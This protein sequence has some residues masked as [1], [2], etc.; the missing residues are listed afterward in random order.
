[1]DRTSSYRLSGVL[2]ASEIAL[3]ATP[4][5]AQDPPFITFRIAPASGGDAF[6]VDTWHHRDNGVSVGKGRDGFVLRIPDCADFRIARDGAAVV[7]APEGGCPAETLAQLLLDQVLPLVLHVHGRFSFHASSVAVGEQHL[8]AFLGQTGAG[9]STLASS[10]ARAAPFV[11]FSDDCLAVEVRGE[12]VVAHPSYDSTRLW[13][14]SAGALFPDPGALA[15]A[16]P[17]TAKLRA[18]LAAAPR[19]MP[20]ERLYLLER[21]EGAP[22][23]TS[24]TRRDALI[25]LAGHLY[26]LDIGDR[27]RLTGELDLLDRVTSLVPVARLAYRRSYD[28]LPAVRDAILADLGAGEAASPP[29]A[30]PPPVRSRG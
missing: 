14:E 29:P 10:L 28:E 19:S 26:R 30:T 18:P 1:M 2:V 23:I 11:L 7:V 3:P 22:A 12:G 25:E 27:A 15:L 24:L 9:K 8:I 16:S 13:P 5:E 21:T 4:T 6:P 17:R 20:L